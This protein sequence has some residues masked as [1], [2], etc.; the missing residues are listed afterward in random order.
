MDNFSGGVYNQVH[1]DNTTKLNF[2]NSM[3]SSALVNSNLTVDTAVRQA[4][5]GTDSLTLTVD[6]KFYL[7]A[8]GVTIKCKAVAQEI[9]VMWEE[10]YIP[11]QITL[12]FS[13]L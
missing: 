7:D 11:L 10:F 5:T 6:S 2:T 12:I 8:N 4:Y 3:S 9:Q 13:H 1:L